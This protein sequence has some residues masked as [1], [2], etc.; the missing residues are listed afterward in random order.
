MRYIQRLNKDVN[1]DN[2]ILSALRKV[3]K[4][5]FKFHLVTI[6]RPVYLTEFLEPTTN[7]ADLFYRP[8]H[9]NLRVLYQSFDIFSFFLI[10]KF[11]CSVFSFF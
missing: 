7:L 3:C 5:L 4:I 11:F 6:Y 10:F 8:I 9:A 1:K 2:E